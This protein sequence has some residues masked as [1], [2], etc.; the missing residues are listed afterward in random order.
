[1]KDDEL[2]LDNLCGDGALWQVLGR[3]LKAAFKNVK[4]VSTP[5]D[6]KRQIT[7]TIDIAPF[8]DR[9]G[10]TISFSCKSKLSGVNTV[11]GTVFLKENA[12]GN[13]DAFVH[14]P[15]Q[16]K[17]FAAEPPASDSKQ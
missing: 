13:V 8:P 12:D 4:D 17:L 1:M 14:D 6:A 10:A 16:E 11:Q 7:L 9:R 2:T 3:E 15:M 5:A